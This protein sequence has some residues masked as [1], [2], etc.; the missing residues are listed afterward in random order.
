MMAT[1]NPTVFKVN[2]LAAAMQ[3]ILTPEDSS[4]EARWKS[5]TP[6]LADLIGRWLEITPQSVLLDYGCG[7]GRIA[8][9]LIARHGCR[10]IGV[11][12]SPS[13]RALAPV[14]VES[15]RFFACAPAM[16]DGLIERG[17]IFDGALS[18]WVLQHCVTPAEDIARI[19]RALRP[20]GRLFVLNN[21]NR[22]VPTLERGWLNDRIDL[23]AEL[24]RE[25]ALLG[26]GAPA[27]EHTTPAVAQG[28]FWAA[29]RRR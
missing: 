3:I 18:I 5:E 8:K 9:E 2:D 14:Y 23:R 24:A 12:I 21:V 19:R 1:Y 11:D 7:I 10:V 29:F 17:V 16:L 26:E 4:T 22:A 13:M 20:E 6:Y 25:F 27:R 15:D 28:S